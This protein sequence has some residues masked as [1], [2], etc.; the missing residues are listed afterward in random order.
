MIVIFYKWVKDFDIGDGFIGEYRYMYIQDKL[1]L[2]CKDFIYIVIQVDFCEFGL[3]V[4]VVNDLSYGL[5]FVCNFFLL[6]VVKLILNIIWLIL[7]NIY[8]I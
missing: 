3:I 5:E 6:I 7:V 4:K 8:N 1:F 2:I